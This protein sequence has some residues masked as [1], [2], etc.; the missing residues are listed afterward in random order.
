MNSIWHKT[1][2]HLI[3]LYF[4]SPDFVQWVLTTRQAVVKNISPSSPHS[5]TIICVLGNSYIYILCIFIKTL[6]LKYLYPNVY[7]LFNAETKDTAKVNIHVYS[8][9]LQAIFLTKNRGANQVH[10]LTSHTLNRYILTHSNLA[11]PIRLFSY[12]AVTKYLC[13]TCQSS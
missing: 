10:A 3:I 1:S 5:T 6:F 11:Q 2:P 12:L 7:N 8:K 9:W 4:R 13:A